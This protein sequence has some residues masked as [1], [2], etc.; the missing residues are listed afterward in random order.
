MNRNPGGRME[1]SFDS[2]EFS[3]F[4]QLASVALEHEARN[5]ASTAIERFS[6]IEARWHPTGFAVFHIA[7]NYDFGDL[8][9][10]IW[11]EGE[12]VVRPFGAPIH[13]H[14]WHLCSRILVGTYSETL[15]EKSVPGKTEA[16]CY[17][18]GD[19][20]YLV[21]KDSIVSGDS[22]FLR[23]KTMTRSV[24]GEFHMVPAAVP[25]ETL[26]EDKSFVATLLMTSRPVSET[27]TMYSPEAILDSSYTRPQVATNK[28][29]EI[30]ERLEFELSSLVTS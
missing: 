16:K 1:N 21:D 4:C 23:P 8:R 20:R 18:S 11:P 29:I 25:H 15:Y 24:S 27:V 26:I 2:R 30:L 12:R 9:L 14:A 28:K 6:P 10:H 17:Q 5:L 22:V 3:S 7:N 19:I 13:T